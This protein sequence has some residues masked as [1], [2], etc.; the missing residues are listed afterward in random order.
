[1]NARRARIGMEPFVP[2]A[3][4]KTAGQAMADML[5]GMAVPLSAVPVAGD[6]AGLAA[7]AAMYATRPEERTLGN[8]ALTLAG[9]LPFVPGA[10]T[11]R[12][13]E[14]ALDMSQAAR[15]QRANEFGGQANWYRGSA[16]DEGGELSKKFLGE[17]TN[18]PSARRGFF[19]ASNP[20][21]AS[22]PSYA[23]MSH[24]VLSD[25]VRARFKQLTGKNNPPEDSMQAWKYL[26]EE[27]PQPIVDE[28]VK[29]G[30]DALYN[31]DYQLKN[32]MEETLIGHIKNLIERDDGEKFA[33]AINGV[34]RYK[35]DSGM[36]IGEVS[37]EL[38]NMVFKY[39]PE[40]KRFTDAINESD[41]IYRALQASSRLFPAWA[42]G[43]EGDGILSDSIFDNANLGAN[44]GKFKLNMQNPYIHDMGGS[45]YREVS[46]DEILANA[47]AGGHDSA[48][49]KNTY[50][51]GDQMTDIGVV[52]E[53]NQAR[54]INA[55]FDPAK[56]NSANLMAGIAVAPIG[57]S[58]LRALIPQ[59]N[60]E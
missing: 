36:G 4:T 27:V 14:K 50:D 22:S 17:N 28:K 1:M 13:A 32:E 2:Q 26:I 40:I 10:S 41:Y 58:A 49:I 56:R 7:D 31:T 11:A 6:I 21:T 20:E 48:I 43:G 39:I 33:K 37:D 47:L 54:S 38:K 53:P 16:M 19:F 60:Q 35:D 45:G 12:A 34:L 59:E 23:T 51:G 3:P 8:A 15:M 9:V 52:F 44:V 55:A 42:R 57:V 29:K 25:Y 46:Y 5:G 24:D 30:F 18:S